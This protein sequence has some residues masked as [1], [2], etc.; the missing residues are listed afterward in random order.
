MEM[1]FCEPTGFVEI[2]TDLKRFMH[3]T[4]SLKDPEKQCLGPESKYP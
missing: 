4:L 2:K 3:A 1:E